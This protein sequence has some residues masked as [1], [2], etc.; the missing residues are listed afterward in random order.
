[1]TTQSPLISVA[2][3]AAA[4]PDA[5]L[6]VDCRFQ[7]ADPA[8]GR[9]DY[10]AGHI[11]GAMYASLDQDLSDLR[12]QGEGRHPLPEPA[13][14]AAS[15]GRWGWQP[16]MTVVAYDAGAGAM[17]AARLWWLMRWAGA[18]ARVLDGGLAA[19]R[20]AGKSLQQGEVA[21]TPTDVQVR[22]APSM[23]VSSAELREGLA[24]GDTV[25]VDARAAARF[26]GETEPVDAVAGHV[27]GAR[28]RPFAGNV[29]G[30]Q[31]WRPA[32]ELRHEFIRLLDGRDPA[33]AVHMCGSGV[34]AC[35]NLLAMEYA[36]LHG[37][38]LYAPSWSGW[39]SDPANPVATG[40][41]PA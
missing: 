22:F 35:H 4:D 5:I 36:G 15:L 25:L 17:T 26:R 18:P 20:A 11:P 21:R 37:S 6:V 10:L 30:E 32:V 23:V 27:P 34:T 14:F 29:D 13:F 39:I 9:R 40:Q 19:W 7:L 24:T 16:G 8:Q 2:E 38:R 33:C 28:N 12:K 41:A 31:R 3:L 1:M